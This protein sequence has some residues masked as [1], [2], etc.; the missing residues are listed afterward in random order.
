[1][2]IL[3]LCPDYFFRDTFYEYRWIVKALASYLAEDP[4][5]ELGIEMK[6]Y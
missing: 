5:E 1:M 3:F 6:I 2:K 4:L